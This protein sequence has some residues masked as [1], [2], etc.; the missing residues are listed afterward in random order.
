MWIGGSKRITYRYS[1]LVNRKQLILCTFIVLKY[2]LV[3]LL[4]YLYLLINKINS[5]SFIVKITLNLR[6][7][8]G[9]VNNF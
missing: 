5:E 4:K 6:V 2:D 1:Y 7:G 8:T 9:T 3:Y